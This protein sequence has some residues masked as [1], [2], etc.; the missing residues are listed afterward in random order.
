MLNYDKTQWGGLFMSFAEFAMSFVNAQTSKT[1]VHP[2]EPS[3]SYTHPPVDDDQVVV[4]MNSK[5]VKDFLKNRKVYVV[6]EYLNGSQSL[7]SV[8]DDYNTA[9]SIVDSRMKDQMDMHFTKNADG[10][11]WGDRDKFA[12]VIQERGFSDAR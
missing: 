9:K 2:R 5:E 10:R 6:S 7:I 11:I 8:E 1:P 3:R 12:L 4:I